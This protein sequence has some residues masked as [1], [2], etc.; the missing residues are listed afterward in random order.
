MIYET[1]A[2]NRAYVGDAED[3][4]ITPDTLSASPRQHFFTTVTCKIGVL[5]PHP[6]C[7]PF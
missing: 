7:L 6:S 2:I 5:P 4:G 1:K 3:T